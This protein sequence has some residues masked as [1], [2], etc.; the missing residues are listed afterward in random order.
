MNAN[1]CRGISLDMTH[2]MYLVMLDG[3]LVVPPI[4]NPQNI[5]DVGTGTGIWAIDAAEWELSEDPG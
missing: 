2:H 5:L 4:E 1:K 3:N